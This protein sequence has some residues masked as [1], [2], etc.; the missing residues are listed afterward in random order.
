MTALIK[1]YFIKIY[2][3]NSY[4]GE[5]WS[6]EPYTLGDRETV[7]SSTSKEAALLK[8]ARVR[9]SA[10]IYTGIHYE[11]ATMLEMPDDSA[12]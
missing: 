9:A 8:L 4:S 7:W 3:Q 6:G 10:V 1:T 2:G 12:T 11:L 5:I